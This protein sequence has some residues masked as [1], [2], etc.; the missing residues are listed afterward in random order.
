LKSKFL[1]I[2]VFSICIISMITNLILFKVLGSIT[3]SIILAFALAGLITFIIYRALT[4]VL[5]KISRVINQIN[6][7]DLVINIDIDES[8][9]AG[10]L[11]L[12]AKK[13]IEGLKENF[14]QQVN[15]S[16]Q[17]V[18]IS[19][20]LNS[21]ANESAETMVN[22]QS[23][24]EVTCDS[25]EKQ[26][27]MLQEISGNSNDIVITLSKMA[28]EM[29]ETA[30]FTKESMIAAE[31]GIDATLSIK[32][33][34]SGI[35]EAV[36]NTG[37]QIESLRE[38]SEKVVSMTDQI[39]SIAQQ[40][41]MLALNASIEAARAGDHGK[42]FSVVADEVGKLSAKTTEV[43]NGI[44]EVVAI[45]QKDIADISNLMKLET[46]QVEASYI[47]VENTMEDFNKINHS[48]LLSVEKVNLMNEAI[49]KVNASGQEVAAMIE[50]ISQFSN[51]IYAQMEESQAQ[52]NLQNEKL[53]V[54]KEIGEKLSKDAD[55]MQQYVASK[56]MEG[57]MLRAITKVRDEL[58]NGTIN[59]DTLIGYAKE[60]GLD[61]IYVTNREGAVD[62][63][64]QRECVGLN[65]YKLNQ[66]LI[67]LREGKASYVTTPIIKRVQDGKLYKYLCIIDKNGRVYQAAL[68]IESLLKF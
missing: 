6:E 44:T 40:T 57:K 60:V 5:K 2:M 59:N 47:E 32:D 45:L 41:N 64:N 10:E 17:I 51:E 61:I 16:T 65:L 29:D 19:D 35:K 25:S 4:S 54:L 26:V 62:Y 33:K 15:L 20:D 18:E 49:G 7:N 9:I 42:G 46:K 34:I 48:L 8:S 43:S 38:Y 58:E 55:Y 39:K 50:E 1:L 36:T 27:Q 22:L 30:A 67:K 53:I 68:S 11:A 28:D 63:C 31:K 37:R 21:I 14:R 52:T 66:N 13:M 24:A 12:E 3:I 23:F 56:V